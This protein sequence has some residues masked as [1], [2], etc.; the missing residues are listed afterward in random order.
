MEQARAHRRLRSIREHARLRG[1]QL[2]DL[3][4]HERDALIVG[5]SIERAVQDRGELPAGEV[6]VGAAARRDRLVGELREGGAAAARG[7]DVLV[8]AAERDRDQER[9]QA[10]IAAKPADRV[11]E[12]QERVVDEILCDIIIADELAREAAERGVMGAIDLV[13]RLRIVVREPRL[14]GRDAGGVRIARDGKRERQQVLVPEGPVFVQTRFARTKRALRGPRRMKIAWLILILLVAPV[15]AQPVTHPDAGPTLGVEVLAPASEV[16]PSAVRAAIAGELAVEVT[17]ATAFAPSL[18][19]L[20]ILVDR[21]EIRIAYHPAA[22]TVIERTLA[23]PVADDERVQLIAYVATNLVR[24]QAS[25]ILAGLRPPPLVP[26]TRPTPRT[27]RRIPATIGFVPGVAVDRVFGERVVVGVGLHV[28][29]GATGGSEYASVSGLVDVQREFANGAQIGGVAA[30][31]RGTVDG[32]QI[33]GVAAYTTDRLHGIQVGGVAA[34]S[35]HVEGVQLG[36]VASIARGRVDGL[37]I[38][39]VASAAERVHGLQIGGVASIARRVD[40]VQLAGVASV[41]GDV[42]GMQIG[43]VNVARRM[44]GVQLGVINLSDDGDDAIP[45]GLVNYARNGRLAAEGWV[46]S[47]RLTAAALRH[48]TRRVHNV[49]AVGWSPDHDHVLVGAGLGAHVALGGATS[50]AVD[51]DTMH[52]LT[53][54]WDGETGQ[55]SQLRASLAIPLGGVEVFGGAATNVYISDEMDESASFHPVLARRTTTSGGTSVVLW[56]SAFVGVR[57]RA[58]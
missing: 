27:T 8:S 48:G 20:E 44:R 49:W 52:W 40:G 42:R 55:L 28:L 33:G 18:G 43:V 37:Q 58:R 4:E 14:E 23:L 16:D 57:L 47:S 45:I 38:G 6:V 30:V 35:R 5:Q 54:V 56:P 2:I 10:G 29:V 15:A 41:G 51:I 50:P 26:A 9:P 46:E 24:D 12:R 34:A 25:E 13:D 21:G 19:R 17:D 36:G 7:A 11:G 3:A 31:S 39:G 32:V 53:N 22:G 1:R